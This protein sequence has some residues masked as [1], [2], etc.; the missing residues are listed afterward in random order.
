MRS[1]FRRTLSI[2]IRIFGWMIVAVFLLL[3]LFRW[4]PVPTTPY[5]AAE[6]LRLGGIQR[7]WVPIEEISPDLRRSV[8]AAE[9]ANF[10]LHWGF[11]VQAIRTA[12]QDGGLR[13]G[14][15]LTQQTA[16]N[17]FL[18]QGRSWLRKGIEAVLTPMLEIV[19]PKRRILEVYLNI[20]E[21]D[22]GVFGAEAAAQWY[23]G[24]SAK[25]LT[26][27][28]A[29]ALATVLPNPKSRSAISLGPGMRS[30]ARSIA[31]GARTIAQDGRAACIED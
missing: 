25:Q 8:I 23:F 14:S 28:Q 19:W 13:G 15:T 21:F 12:L 22:T 24:R 26:L 6:S 2:A 16:K 17:L 7:V 18:W 20:A 1:L 3:L 10:C 27:S 5:M 30:R 29:S 31:S 11:D 4:V 9:D